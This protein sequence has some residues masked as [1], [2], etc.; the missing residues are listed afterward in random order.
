MELKG[1]DEACEEDVSQLKQALP[2]NVNEFLKHN[3]VF[4]PTNVP[5][6]R[7][8]QGNTKALK[9]LKI[10]KH[11]ANSCLGTSTGSGLSVSGKA[12]ITFGV[13]HSNDAEH[14]SSVPELETL[15]SRMLKNKGN[16]TGLND[17]L[18][19]Y[20]SCGILPPRT[21]VQ[22]NVELCPLSIGP[23]EAFLVI[24]TPSSQYY[25]NVIRR[26]QVHLKEQEMRMSTYQSGLN[27]TALDRIYKE[28]CLVTVPE[29]E[30][31]R[32][33]ESLIIRV[34]TLRLTNL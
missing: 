15:K 34:F 21:Q 32:Y 25:A 16:I 18:S 5:T 2:G 30:L 23:I 8:T 3:K 4:V 33:Q 10:S 26:I 9:E 22:I 31:I 13:T 17:V 20:P 14:T 29:L 24:N 27:K 19:V 1:D 28:R 12:S 6:I 7:T 11:L